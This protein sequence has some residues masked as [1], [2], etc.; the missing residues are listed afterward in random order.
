LNLVSHEVL[1]RDVQ[2]VLERITPVVRLGQVGQG[3]LEAA[4]QELLGH[5]QRL[6][7]VH[8]FN[9]LFTSCTSILQ[10]AVL[11]L[12]ALDLALHFF[13]PRVA[14]VN[15]TLLVFLFVLSDLIEFGLFF[16]FEQGLLDS[17]GQEHVQD[18]LN[19]TVVIKE[20]VIFDLSHLVN[21]GFLWHILWR[22]GSWQEHIGLAFNVLIFGLCTALFG[23]K[24]AEI[25]LNACRWARD[26]VIR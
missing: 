8:S 1:V 15:L 25:H 14:Q 20:V 12:D 7:F 18:G 4:R 10:I 22:F 17:L 26:Q 13:L 16:D 5:V 2:L 21:T 6:K 3:A 11:V 19:F 24:V 23:Q 9:L